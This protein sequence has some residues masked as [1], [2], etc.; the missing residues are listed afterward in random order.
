[1]NEL[2]LN[3]SAVRIALL[4]RDDAE[5]LKAIDALTILTAE[6]ISAHA[7]EPRI[8]LRPLSEAPKDADE[9]L[10]V[11]FQE[12]GPNGLVYITISN[13]CWDAEE[14][15]WVLGPRG[16]RTNCCGDG[17]AT[18]WLP[19]G[20][21]SSVCRSLTAVQPSTAPST[22]ALL[23]R[24]S[25]EEQGILNAEVAGSNPAAPATNA[26]VAEL[27]EATALNSGNTA[28]SNPA[29]GT[30]YTLE[31]LLSGITPVNLHGEVDF[32]STATAESAPTRPEQM[33][34]PTAQTGPLTKGQQIVAKYEADMIA[35]PC[36]LAAAIDQSLAEVA[37]S[38]AIS[39]EPVAWIDRADNG[40]IRFWTSDA[41]RAERERAAGRDLHPYNMTRLVSLAN[42]ALQATVLSPT[43][44]AAMTAIAAERERQKSVEGYTS[45]HDDEHFDG[46]IADAAACY[47]LATTR[48]PKASVFANL[49]PWDLLWWKPTDKRRNLVKAGALIVAEIERLD[50]AVSRKEGN[51]HG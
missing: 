31:G 23:A 26:P 49:W 10:L 37:R 33:V 17:V 1:M 25:T 14:E 13:G 34:D 32:C 4:K 22:N 6:D 18:H 45:Q 48:G 40:N 27:V 30:N 3:R 2:Y 9:I 24:S 41:D 36:E 38:T 7:P 39:D 44:S 42:I 5:G 20:A 16:C 47:A 11:S 43:P 19:A 51:T 12:Q 35:E 28:G 15:S 29:G 8:T 21:L 46:Q 50:R